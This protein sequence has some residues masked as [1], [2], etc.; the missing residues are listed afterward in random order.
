[1]GSAYSNDGVGTYA[2]SCKRGATECG[3]GACCCCIQDPNLEEELKTGMIIADDPFFDD[4]TTDTEYKKSAIYEKDP[5]V[6]ASTAP[7]KKKPQTQTDYYTKTEYY[8]KDDNVVVGQP[9]EPVIVPVPVELPPP[10]VAA[11]TSSAREGQ[12]KVLEWI[13]Q[14]KNLKNKRDEM[15]SFMRDYLDGQPLKLVRDS[16]KSVGGICTLIE[17]MTELRLKINNKVLPIPISHIEHVLNVGV[18]EIQKVHNEGKSVQSL[19][20]QEEKD[21]PQDEKTHVTIQLVSGGFVT[22]QFN[23]IS[24]QQRFIEFIRILQTYNTEMFK[25]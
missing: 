11:E 9:V 5:S 7:K 25:K 3:C 2:R 6:G 24:E 14:K 18:S 10:E 4:S 12:D 16:G 19:M 13:D 1:M 23:K 21:K 15:E 22:V 20:W 17:S 8:E